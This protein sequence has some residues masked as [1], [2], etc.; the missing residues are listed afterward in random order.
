MA[1]R[2]PITAVPLIALA[3]LGAFMAAC[4]GPSPSATPTAIPAL[5]TPVAQPS[6]P[7]VEPDGVT[8][9]V[10]ADAADCEEQNDELVAAWLAAHD[11][12]IA[13]AGDVAYD[14]GT[15]QQFRDC[16]EP[17]WGPLKAR[18]KPVPGNHDYLTPGAAPYWDYFGATAGERGKGWYSFELGEWHIIGLNSNCAE[19][20][21]CG[22]GS[23]QYRW[24][25]ADLA[26]STAQCTLVFTHH[27]VFTSGIH[28]QDP[29]GLLPA[30]ALLYRSGVDLFAAG[31]DHHYE[32]FAPLDA[33]GA[34]D[35][36]FGI[37]G[38]VAGTGGGAL[39][40]FFVNVA[41]SEARDGKTNGV[42]AFELRPGSYSWSFVPI[43]KGTFTDAGS[44]L[45]HA[46]P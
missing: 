32:R 27:P 38:F 46:R 5:Q 22:P 17:A 6:P 7:Q 31:H 33:A 9:F 19:A 42:L 23:P 35:E 14:K 3:I 34:R 10:V 2:R 21:G 41:N 43:G 20:G 1:A 45:C 29:A 36:A 13:L 39:Y 8:L 37:R 4:G 26:A 24:L 18:I 44:G 12:T 40:P 16:F 15:A 11:G 28:G 25:E 30:W